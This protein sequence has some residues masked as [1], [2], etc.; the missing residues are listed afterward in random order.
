MAADVRVVFVT[1]PRDKAQEMARLVVGNRLAACV[2]IAPQIESFYWWEGQ[3]RSDNEALLIMKTTAAKFDDLRSFV[4]ENH[5]Y[6]LPE[7]IALPVEQGFEAYLKWVID[8]TGER[9]A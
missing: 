1:I 5:P 7:I 3:V 9:T 8:E 2:N 6:D 4:V